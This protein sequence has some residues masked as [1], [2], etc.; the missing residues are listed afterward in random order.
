M[1]SL[2]TW[3]YGEDLSHGSENTAFEENNLDT[4]G[5]ASTG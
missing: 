5:V 1:K 4:A 2:S 3:E